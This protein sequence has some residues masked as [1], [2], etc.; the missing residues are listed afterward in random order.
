MGKFS[1]SPLDRQ[2]IETLE[3]LSEGLSPVQIAWIAGYYAALTGNLETTTAENP[4]SKTTPQTSAAAVTILYGSRT[5]NGEGL[6]KKAE[7]LAQGLGVNVE[8][9]SMETY[10]ARDLK[11]EQNLLVIV[12]THGEGE[13]PFAAQELHSFLF[14]KRAPK[15]E[16]LNF[17]VLALGDSS[18]LKYCQTGID[19]DEQLEKLGG[20][21]IADRVECDVDFDADATAWLKSTLVKFSGETTTTTIETS[22]EVTSTENLFDKNNP[23]QSEVLEKIQLYGEGSDRS[24]LHLELDTE[25]QYQPGDSLGI[26]PQNSEQLIKELLKILKLEGAEKV[27]WKEND[28]TLHDALKHQ[29]ELSK[30]TIDVL[31]RLQKIVTSE[32]LDELLSNKENLESYLYG[33]DIIDLFKEFP[34]KLTALE[35]LQLLR[36]IQPRLYSIAS[37]N[38]AVPGE[39]HLTVSVVDYHHAGRNKQGACSGYLNIFDD[40]NLKLSVFVEENQNFRLPSDPQKPIIMIG[41]GT[42]IAPFR[43]F[44]QHR[45]VNEHPGKN[46]IFFGNRNFETEFLYQT[47]WQSY[48]K[49]GILTK[50]DVA[51]SRDAEEKVYVQNRLNENAKEVYKWLQDGAHLYICGD[52]KKMAGDVQKALLNIIETEGGM[53]TDAANEYFNLLQ[54]ERRL[55]LDVY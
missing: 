31:K 12:S 37:S 7:Q 54:K 27:I 50:M 40:E 22:V 38:D 33:R 36:P 14:G 21:R 30:I 16:S 8:L 9:K 1:I 6:A 52:M 29:F 44:L 28:S 25:L 42:G 5:G 17:A 41:A 24:T 55:Q 18:Y 3:Q 4:I 11:K 13:P 48:L 47:E 35:L 15:F 45:E 26:L 19:F 39:V 20:K 32:K 34:V 53:T 49:N 10:K 51:F 2:K 23:Y 43:A 46:W